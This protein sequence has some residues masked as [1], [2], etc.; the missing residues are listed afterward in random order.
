MGIDVA[1]LH[2]PLLTVAWEQ[3][4]CLKVLEMAD[5][6]KGYLRGLQLPLQNG[7]T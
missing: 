1:V 7:Y 2:F 4:F 6:G 5:P 3:P